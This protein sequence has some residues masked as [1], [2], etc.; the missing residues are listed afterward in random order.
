MKSKILKIIC[1]LISAVLLFSCIGI[2][3]FA[4]EADTTKPRF[5]GPNPPVDGGIYC[6]SKSIG[7]TD[8]NF[9]RV[10]VDG[11]QV[12]V[13]HPN[14]GYYFTVSEPG[15]H[16]II[17]YD[18][19]G[20]TLPVHITINADHTFG[21][22]VQTKE[23]TCLQR[24]NWERACKYCVKKEL[25]ST[26]DAEF[27][28]HHLWGE[29][30][31]TWSED[32]K[33]ASAAFVCE[34]S[35]EHTKVVEADITA[36]VKV[37]A[38]CTEKGTTAYTATV[39]LD[40]NEYT[41]I[42]EIQDI[43]PLGHNWQNGVCTQCG[44]KQPVTDNG[45]DEPET[46]PAA[47]EHSYGEWKYDKTNHWR[48][49]ACG[50]RIEV[51]AHTYK[52]GKCTVCKAVDPNYKSTSPATGNDFDLVLPVSFIALSGFAIV[53]ICAVSRKRASKCSGK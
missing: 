40:G 48:E 51:N 35:E 32:G 38:S 49:C 17:V 15:E 50:E 3:A 6:I 29:P 28:L 36:A 7:V 19:S 12:S 44:V 33:T 41:D 13:T 43:A 39:T 52:D 4:D 23:P 26:T 14:A 42:K 16:E 27:D 11:I 53:V 47:H 31:F 2:T 25:R 37:P 21:E 18:K 34:R 30:T 5:Y 45:K 8:E 20:N 46:Q 24:G 22:W 9:D 1:A 10:E